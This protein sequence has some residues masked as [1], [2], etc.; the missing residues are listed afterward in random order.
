[1]KIAVVGAGYVGLTWA[2]V[3]ASLSHKVLLVENN[4]KKL[5]KLKKGQPPFFEPGLEPLLKKEIKSKRLSF[6]SSIKDLQEKPEVVF[7]CVGTPSRQDGS[8]DLSYVFAVAKE[9]GKNLWPGQTTVVLK[10]TVLPGTT[11][12]VEEIISQNKNKKA[13]FSLA[14]CPEFLREGKAV[15]D[16]FRPNRVIIGSNDK[17]AIAILKKIHAPFGAPILAVKT[18]SAE[19]TKYAAN[20][21]LALRIVFANQIADLAERVGAEVEEVIAG[22]GL[23]PRIGSAYWYPG[24]GYGGSCF[25][26]DVAALASFST[27]KGLKQSL[28]SFMDHYNQSRPEKKL[29]EIEEKWGQALGKRVAVWGLACK[30]GTDDVRG[31][32]A[33]LMAD[34]LSKKG[35]AVFAFDAL[36]EENAQRACPN[37][38]YSP[39]PYSVVKN[40]DWL[41]VLSDDPLFAKANFARVKKLM[42]GRKIFDAR[43]ILPKEELKKMGFD[44]LGVGRI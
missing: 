17:R 14:F 6:S 28:F 25:P 35:A 22:I 23:D 11:K 33:L 30:Q 36:A 5:A 3:L 26:K 42:R 12:K 1:M 10:S 39:D 7:I 40:V 20:A 32:A 8:I 13:T 38:C 19:V 44:Y 43:N 21:Y 27:K 34:K 2:A 31:S 9:L 41:L 15:E 24:L 37:V 18:E 16:S 4:P 29:A